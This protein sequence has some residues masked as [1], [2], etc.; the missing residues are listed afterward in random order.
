MD[1]GRCEVARNIWFVIR[2]VQ[3]HVNSSHQ[4]TAKWVV[5]LLINR[6]LNLCFYLGIAIWMNRRKNDH[7]LYRFSV[8]IPVRKKHLQQIPGLCS[9]EHQP[10][11]TS[12]AFSRFI[13]GLQL[14]MGASWW[15]CLPWFF[16]DSRPQKN[17]VT[18]H[19]HDLKH[20]VLC[21]QY[22]K[23]PSLGRSIAHMFSRRPASQNTCNTNRKKSLA[24]EIQNYVEPGLT[25]PDYELGGLRST[26]WNQLLLRLVPAHIQLR[27]STTCPSF[28]E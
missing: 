28:S 22:C 18:W 10:L 19:K 3:I 21:I 5:S 12:D 14:A 16:C 6:M 17:E 26:Q 25:N 27:V 15:N 23:I 24:S 1:G 7:V 4:F 2:V 13:V 8:D 20:D 11:A 9:A